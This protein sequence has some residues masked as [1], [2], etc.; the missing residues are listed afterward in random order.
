LFFFAIGIG[1]S[2]HT[3]DEH[4]YSSNGHKALGSRVVFHIPREIG[5][6]ITPNNRVAL[7]YEHASNGM[8]AY[9]NP[10]QDNIGLRL[11]HRF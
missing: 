6:R 5:V 2:I 1:P 7:N 8:T 9:P 11:T 3:G 10:G 4:Y